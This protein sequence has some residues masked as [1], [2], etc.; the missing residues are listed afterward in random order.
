MSSAGADAAAAGGPHHA[1]AAQ[2][3]DGT[4][5]QPCGFGARMMDIATHAGGFRVLGAP[6]DEPEPNL[7][8]ARVVSSIPKSDFTPEH[9]REGK[10]RW[11][12]PS[13]D[14]YYKAMKRKGWEPEP[15]QMRT[16]VAI[17]NTVNEQS[18]REVLKWESFHPAQEPPKLKRFL[19]KPTEYSPK[20]RLMNLF[21][22][23][24]LPFDR[25]DWIVERDGK[26]VR[27]VID[28]YSGQPEPGRP[29]SV[30][31]DVRPA[32]DSVD[33]FVD[34]LR[35]QF[36]E[37]IMP[38]LP[39]RGA[40]LGKDDESARAPPSTEGRSSVIQRNDKQEQH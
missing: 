25:H 12:Y 13:E 18:W 35:W 9:Q 22:W 3:K 38:L 17:H 15:E 37:K 19:G 8:K 16:I 29:M 20:A 36:H 23:S 28:F 4:A 24:V 32:L 5:E 10:D 30:Y 26:E 27:Y 31:L 11:E 40:F 33:G 14:M 1:Q 7:S 2:G 34:R 39:F 6:E 21:G